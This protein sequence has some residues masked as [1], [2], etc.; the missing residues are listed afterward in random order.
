MKKLFSNVNAWGIKSTNSKWGPWIL[1]LLGVADASFFPLPVT[2]LFVAIILINSQKTFAYIVSLTAGIV[3]G[4]ALGYL[5]GR[6][7]WIDQKSHFTGIAQFFINNLP[8]FSAEAYLKAHLLFTKWSSLILLI[9][10]VTPLPYGLFSVSSG[11]FDINILIFLLMTLAG[12]GIKYLL[13]A[14]LTR[15]MG[16]SIT[17]LIKF[18][19]RPVTVIPAACIVIAVIILKVV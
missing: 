16:P 7:A 15:K 13:L 1:C 10:T 17:R 12:H 9:A 14:L 11:V 6:Y 2:T 4:A 5:T 19:W 18:T 3:L 8:G